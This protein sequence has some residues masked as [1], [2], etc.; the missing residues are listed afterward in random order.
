MLRGPGYLGRGAVD[1]LGEIIDLAPTIL[2]AA[3]V[4]SPACYRGSALADRLDGAA[5]KKDAVFAQISESETCRCVRTA[6]WK[7]GVSGG[8]SMDAL[9]KP[10][11][12][13]YYETYLYDLEA[14]PA[15]LNNLAEDARFASA[16][17]ELRERLLG[18][19]RSVECKTPRILPL[20]ARPPKKRYSFDMTLYQMK[21]DERSLAL[22]RRYLPLLLKS[23]A[24]R[25]GR[26]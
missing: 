14:D 22:L 11:A 21:Q 10:D 23:K 18:W 17:A 7:Y 15:E 6:R 5:P 13:V 16:R 20:D 2:R 19:I 4:A 25:L 3:G 1:E 9:T 8:S 24:V 26:T 12:D